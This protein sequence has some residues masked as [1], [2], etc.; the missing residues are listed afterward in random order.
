VL[1]A[2]GASFVTA[3]VNGTSFAMNTSASQLE[4]LRAFGYNEAEARFLY[5]VAT[6]SGYFVA[7]QFHAF[8]GVYWG[9]QTTCFWTKLHTNK[10]VCTEKFPMN[11][12]VY[13]RIAQRLYRQIG[14]ENTFRRPQ[15]HIHQIQR[16]IALLDFVLAHPQYHYLETESEKVSFFRDHLKVG[17]Y[18]LPSKTYYGPRTCQP[19]VRHFADCF[20]MF[21][22]DAD[23]SS[24]P[25]VTFTYLQG[26]E[27]SLSGF[28]HHLQVYLPLFRQ[29]PEFRFLYVARTDSLFSEA[30]ELFEALVTIPLRSD[31]S[32][33][34]LRYFKIRKA[35]DLSPYSSLSETDL[36]F[37]NQATARFAGEHFEHLYRGW[38]ANRVSEA[39]MRHELGGGNQQTIAHFAV[40]VLCQLPAS[41]QRKE[42][43][44]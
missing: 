25:V 24:S 13:R 15:H 38:K 40:E 19:T 42:A 5:I 39:D 6:H 32:A 43:T 27:A 16:R 26:P 44:R 29:L 11:R 34:L 14:R 20:P 3:F 28:T 9:Q 23:S 36:L 18:F 30:K 8:A 33:D 22:Q 37:R 12:T 31:L 1:P 10:H 4:T 35:W 17:N 2:S 7:R 21:V 41:E